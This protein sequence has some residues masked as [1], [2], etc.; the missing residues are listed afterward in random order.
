MT[1]KTPSGRKQK[2]DKRNNDSPNRPIDISKE[3]KE[4]RI[5]QIE[6]EIDKLETRTQLI[7]HVANNVLEESVSEIRKQ[8]EELRKEIKNTD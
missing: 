4:E 1:R 7:K 5:E 3:S 8:T 2:K 6:K